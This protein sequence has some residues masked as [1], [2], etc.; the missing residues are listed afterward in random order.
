MEA[1][2]VCPVLAGKETPGLSF[3]EFPLCHRG[4]RLDRREAEASGKKGASGVSGLL[5]FLPFSPLPPALLPPPR[6][7]LIQGPLDH[8]TPSSGLSGFTGCVAF[9]AVASVGLQRLPC[10]RAG[11]GCGRHPKFCSLSAQAQVIRRQPLADF[12]CFSHWP[13]SEL[14]FHG[15]GGGIPPT[16]A[17]GPSSTTKLEDSGYFAKSGKGR[18]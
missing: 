13:T 10:L 6:P 7:H 9:A 8:P 16:S 5:V 17:G 4:G 1:V 12:C 14:R 3:G 11:C 18:V 15:Q 2:G